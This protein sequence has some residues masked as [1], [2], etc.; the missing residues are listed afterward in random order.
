MTSTVTSGTR[1]I[2]N[3]VWSAGDRPRCHSCRHFE[4]GVYTPSQAMFAPSTIRLSSSGKHCFSIR[5][6][7]AIA[8]LLVR[9]VTT[10]HLA[11]VMAAYVYRCGQRRR[12]RSAVETEAPVIPRNS[13]DLFNRGVDLWDTMFWDARVSVIAGYFETPAGTV[14]QLD[15]IVFL[16]HR[17]CSHRPLH[18][19]R[20]KQGPM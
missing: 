19:M 3:Q 14:C 9:P 11:R 7:V 18:E 10:L 2:V 6:L 8:T 5:S 12:P 13:P 16:R 15:S 20:V 17:L 4:R 1:K